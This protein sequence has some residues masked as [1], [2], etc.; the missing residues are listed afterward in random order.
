VQTD[1]VKEKVL[2]LLS[3]KD[4]VR[5]GTKLLESMPMEGVEELDVG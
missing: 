4:G 3:C 5:I 1:L 2:M